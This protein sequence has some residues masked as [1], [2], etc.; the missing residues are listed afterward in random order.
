MERIR[1][2]LGLGLRLQCPDSA[3]NSLY[4]SELPV[5]IRS[6]RSRVKDRCFR[7]EGE[8]DRERMML[9]QVQGVLSCLR[10]RHVLLQQISFFE[11]RG[12]RM[13]G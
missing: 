12:K 4:G 5:P 2:S 9:L 11:V 7:W 8:G 13:L 10:D 1:F 6:P 3:S